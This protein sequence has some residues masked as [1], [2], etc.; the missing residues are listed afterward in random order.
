MKTVLQLLFF[1][2]QL[3]LPVCVTLYKPNAIHSPLLKEKGEINTSAVLGLSGTGLYNLQGAYALSDHTGILMDGMVHHRSIKSADNSVERLT[4]FSVEA[5]AGYFNT[6]GDKRTGIFQCY[7]GSGFG[8]SSDKID[9][10]YNTYPEASAS[11]INLFIQPGVAYSG[12][13]SSVAFDLRANYVYLYHVNAYLYDRFEFWNT[14]SRLYTDATLYFMNL[15]PAVTL[16]A[17]RGKLK[18]FL[19][20]GLTIPTLNA[21]SFFIINTET[22]LAVPLIKLSAGV[23]YTFGKKIISD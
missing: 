5:G 17:G 15:E 20:L 2:M 9:N 13:S 22:L 11:A 4:L 12:K 19:Q 14:E 8:H 3:I 18:G 10:S 21:R 23:S 7:A 6:F 16:K 1:G